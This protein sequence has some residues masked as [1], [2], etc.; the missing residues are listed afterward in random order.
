M[1][2]RAGGSGIARTYFDYSNQDKI[3]CLATLGQE[4]FLAGAYAEAPADALLKIFDFRSG[5]KPYSWMKALPC[6]DATP[7]PRPRIP[8]DKPRRERNG[9]QP[10]GLGPWAAGL[11]GRTLKACCKRKGHFLL[12]EPLGCCE[13]H[14]DAKSIYWTP[15]TNVFLPKRYYKCFDPRLK[16]DIWR[17]RLNDIWSISVPDYLSPS[18]YLGC[19]DKVMALELGESAPTYE[20]PFQWTSYGQQDPP[21]LRPPVIQ[22]YGIDSFGNTY[23]ETWAQR[24]LHTEPPEERVAMGRYKLSIPYKKPKGEPENVNNITIYETHAALG[25]HSD[26]MIQKYA[27]FLPVLLKRGGPFKPDD[28][29]KKDR[30]EGLK[31][32]AR[33]FRLDPQWMDGMS[34]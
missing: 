17:P 16:V 8:F 5:H 23:P 33:E 1:D 21:G 22:N 11:D 25:E 7:Y 9:F 34:L 29:H 13:F 28:R 4:R 2:R 26:E 6:S 19:Y 27:T 30:E 14:D 32:D 12:R 15:N 20:Q 10:C 3:V 18:V 24:A 31:K